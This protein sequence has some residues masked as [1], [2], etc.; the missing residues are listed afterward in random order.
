MD[1][2][3]VENPQI[4]KKILMEMVVHQL[5]FT[6]KNVGMF[7]NQLLLLI[8]SNYITNNEKSSETTQYFVRHV[9]VNDFCW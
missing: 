3:S 7:L 6:L 8:I 9:L 5:M 4:S 2:E 1:H